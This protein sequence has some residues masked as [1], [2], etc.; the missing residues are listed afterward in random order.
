MNQLGTD[1]WHMLQLGLSIG[2]SAAAVTAA[3]WGLW[4]LGQRR[5]NST[6]GLRNAQAA[7]LDQLACTV[8][9]A[10]VENLLGVPR[11]IL[12][13]ERYYSLP[14]GWVGVQYKSDAVHLLSIT[15]SDSD[16]W[17]RTGGMTLETIDVKLGHDTFADEASGRFDGQQLWIGNKQAGYYRHYHFG[18]AGGGHQHFWLSYNASGAGGID[19]HGPYSSGTCGDDGDTVPDPAKITANTLTILS[20]FGSVADVGNRGLFGPHIEN[21]NLIWSE[22]KKA[23]ARRA[24]LVV[25]PHY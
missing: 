23:Q 21:L 12:G 3:I 17:Y 5:W 16:L 6:L 1:G 24:W 7:I 2:A 9:L 15:I 19:W 11:F 18:G 13:N 25:K 10:Y 22:R 4:K 14:G 8:S 20:P